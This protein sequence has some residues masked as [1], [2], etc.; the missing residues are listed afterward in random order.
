M[1]FKKIL[2]TTAA[3]F[4]AA[5]CVCAADGGVSVVVNDKPIDTDAVIEGGRTLV[6]LR[7][8]YE[9]LGYSVNWDAETKTA[10]F[11]GSEHTMT[12]DGRDGS[13]TAD[14]EKVETDVPAQIIN[15]R[16]Y[17]PLRAASEGLG[18]AVEW[19]GETK[20]VYIKSEPL[21]ELPAENT[22]VIEEKLPE[23]F[24]FS[25][26]AGGWG[27]FLNMDNDGTFAGIY[28][29]SEMGST[30]EDFPDG[31]VYVCGFSSKFAVKGKNADGSYTLK[32]EELAS[33]KK[34]GEEWIEKGIKYIAAVPY[35][36]DGGD[37]FVLYLPGT[38]TKDLSEE[39]LSWWPG[40]FDENADK[41]VLDCFGL[42]NTA[43]DR[44]FFG[45]MD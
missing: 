21:T 43:D 38:P 2:L 30:G 20:T 39:F 25:S 4:A 7:G 15:D 1:K 17:L 11:V 36:L 3:V 22:A 23:Q 8:V 33:D 19:D 5:V 29:D 14:G 34:E 42:R 9:Q 28:S 32:L 31:T 18:L 37:E 44:G 10:A 40:R 45:Y 6:P 16:L 26:G 27:T 35:G 24:E 41:E 12:V 13:V